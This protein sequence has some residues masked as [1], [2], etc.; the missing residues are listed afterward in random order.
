MDEFVAGNESRSADAVPRV[1]QSSA[2]ISIRTLASDLDMI[3]KNGGMTGGSVQRVEM[4]PEAEAE[5]GP[6]GVAVP[7]IP[8]PARR[9]DA[10]RMLVI[11]A[12]IIVIA[13]VL[14]AFGFYIAPLFG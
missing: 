8:R 3:G 9:S 13:G 7:V 10:A 2:E 5:R 11:V 12:A 4:A 6:A 1:P 14:F